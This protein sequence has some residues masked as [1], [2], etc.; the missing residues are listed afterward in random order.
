MVSSDEQ[1]HRC[2]MIEVLAKV[3][4]RFKSVLAAYVWY[5][6]EPLP[7]FDNQTAMQLVNDGFAAEVLQYVDAF[8]AGVY[9]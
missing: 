9:A 7:G 5:R 4:P 8:D 2:E 6:A 3:K 1:R